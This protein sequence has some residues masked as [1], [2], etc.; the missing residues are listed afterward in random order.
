M[1]KTKILSERLFLRAPNIHVCFISRLEGNFTDG[2]FNE[3]VK[4]VCQRHPVLECTIKID[5]DNHA[6]LIPGTGHVGIEFHSADEGLTWYDWYKKTDAVP[7]NFSAGPLVKICVI[8]HESLTELIIFG[9]HVIGDGM[10]Y[11][12]LTKDIIAALDGNSDITPL[13]PPL[14]NDLK[15]NIR[16]GFLPRIVARK[17]N[18][19]WALN[20]HAFSE[21]EY[22]T[23]FKQHRAKFPPGMY[24]DFIEGAELSSLIAVC[25]TTGLTVNE[26]ISSAF[27]GAMLGLRHIYPKKTIDLGIAVNIRNDLTIPLPDSMGD[28]VSGVT[29]YTR[30]NNKKSFIDNAKH[31]AKDTRKKLNN[32]KSRL[33]AVNFLGEIEKDFIEST[34]FAAYGDYKNPVSKKLCHMIGSINAR[35]KGVGISN[36]GRQNFMQYNSFKLLDVLF[37][38]P[39]FPYSMVTVGIITTNNKLNFVLRYAKSEISDDTVKMIYKNAKELMCAM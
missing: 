22:C 6:W 16:L 26:V 21:E 12:N 14:Q 28:Y 37:V 32:K 34:Q 18:K 1:D 31:I 30:Y 13:I 36:L 2:H 10:G 11:L 38:P 5:E 17:L 9:H 35:T 27:V 19:K 20:R 4:T 24:T 39:V 33:L 23:L 8:R 7:F 15:D 3:A 25:K 29:V